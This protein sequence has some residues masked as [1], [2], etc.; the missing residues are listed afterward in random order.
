MSRDAHHQTAHPQT[1]P[2]ATARRLSAGRSPWTR[3][4]AS[5]LAVLLLAYGLRVWLLADTNF[6]WD[7]GY[8]VWISR[9]APLALFDTTA[10]DVHPPLYYLLLKAA[11]AVAGEG[12]FALRYSSVLLGVVMTAL[13]YRL[14]QALG[15]VW[16][17]VIAA[18]LLAVARANVHIAQ[19][20]R[21]HIL[22]TTLATLAL[23]AAVVLWRDMGHR[24]AWAGYVVG[25]AGALYSFYL[26]VMLPLALNAAYLVVWGL[27]WRARPARQQWRDAR[28][29]AALQAVAAGLFIPWALYARARMFG[30]SSDTATPPGFFTQFYA[31]TLTVGRPTFDA[32]QLPFMGVYLLVLLAGTAA[33]WWRERPHARLLLLAA[34]IVTPAVVV[35]LLSLPFHD[36]GRPLAARYMLP[37]SA[38]FYALAAWGIVALGRWRRGAGAL[39]LVLTVGV[40]AWGMSNIAVGAVRRDDLHSIARVLEARRHPVDGVI[41]H[42]DRTWTS[43]A[44]H[45]AGDFERVPQAEPVTE[46]YTHYLLEPWKEAYDGIWL[47]TTPSAAENDPEGRVFTYFARRSERYQT[48]TFNDHTL[49]LFT[50]RPER[51]ATFAALAAST[52]TTGPSGPATSRTLPAPASPTLRHAERAF[53]RYPLGDTVS[54]LLTWDTPPTSP[55]TVSLITDGTATLSEQVPPPDPA[56]HGPTPQI[57]T[58][59]LP[60][61]LPPGRYTLQLAADGARF[62][63]GPVQAAQVGGSVRELAGPPGPAVDVDAAFARDGTTRLMLHGYTLPRQTVRAGGTLAVTLHW[64]AA[65]TLTERY[66]VSVYLLGEEINPATGTPLYAQV[67]AEPVNWTLPTTRWVPGALVVDPYTL[68]VARTV[69]AGDYTLG[70]VVYHPATGARLTVAGGDALALTTV[71]VR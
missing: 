36:L 23:W 11:R 44:A 41:F 24:R 53:V 37:L 33:L 6:N 68:E 52:S 19:L 3:S 13:T 66:K 59:P 25:T 8:S 58:L 1:R 15:G 45:Y 49:T 7:E 18:L 32:G 12:E 10:R 21:M 43:L 17:G 5:L 65:T 27:R 39:G 71:R 30:W 61:T 63:L 67:D 2:T 60:A 9:L 51:T 57:I 28:T 48:W 54:V 26:T 14:G 40:A 62:P 42:N 38:T 35:F 69:P 29:W 31:T 47:V 20:A 70:V 22:A 64:T 55:F 4:G 50:L 16:V 56:P 46:S 34:G